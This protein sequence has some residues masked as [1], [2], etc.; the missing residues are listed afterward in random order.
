MLHFYAPLKN[1]FRII[2]VFIIELENKNNNA[3]RKAE[4]LITV[5][6]FKV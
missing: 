6:H 4:V 5:G 2:T 3:E 1:L